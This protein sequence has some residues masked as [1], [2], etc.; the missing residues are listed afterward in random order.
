MNPF[1]P[2]AR[3][4]SLGID[5]AET[6][7][8]PAGAYVNVVEHGGL[9]LVAGHGP[10]RHGRPA[11]RGKVPTEVSV[12]QAAEACRL[13][14]LN[15]LS[16]LSNHL[17]SI[18]RVGGV[19]RILGMVNAEPTFEQHATVL[20]G[21]SQLIESVFGDAAPHVR[22][23]VGMSSLPFGIPVELEMTAWAKETA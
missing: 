15:C 14:A 1:I 17:G 10:L 18:D 6:N 12:E 3:L 22:A 8:S 20:D 4:A 13:A 2:S 23:A 11:I 7:T 5:L 21:A 19:L 16:S 9:L